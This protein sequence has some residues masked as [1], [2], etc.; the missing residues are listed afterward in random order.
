[1]VTFDPSKYDT[2][3]GPD[4]DQAGGGPCNLGC[5]KAVTVV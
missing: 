1:M 2:N 5:R 3:Q 4:W